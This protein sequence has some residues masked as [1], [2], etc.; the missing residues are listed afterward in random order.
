MRS[1]L[2]GSPGPGATHRRAAKAPRL[3]ALARAVAA[4]GLLAGAPGPMAQAVPAL[5]GGAQVQAG[6]ATITT[7]GAQMTVRNS[8]GTVLNWQ[9]FNIGAG[10]GVHFEQAGASSRVL[11]RVVG[12]DPSQIFG[13]LSSNGQVWLLNPHGVL[14]GA[15]ARVDVAGLVASTLRLSDNDFLAGRLR[16]AAAEGDAATAVRNEGTLATVNGGHVVLLGSR[17]E[18][19]GDVQAP[20]GQAMLVAG[21]TV[22]LADT[23]LPHIGVRLREGAGEVLNAGSIRTPGGRIDLHAAIVNHEGVLRADT[24]AP[25]AEGR[26]VLRAAETLTLGPRSVTAATGEGGGRGGAVDLLG[27]RVALVG[28]ARVDVSGAEGGGSVRLGGGAQGRDTS[29]PNARAVYIGSGAELNAD[30]SGPRG[31]G[32]R[33]VVWSDEATRAY[34]RFSAR[35]GAQGGDGGF[36]ETSGGW[37]DARPAAM[38]LGARFGRPGQWLLDPYDLEIV[39][40][41]QD[42]NVGVGAGPVFTS[43]GVRS[44]LT[45]AT[46]AAALNGGASVRVVTGTAPDA[47]QPGDILMN[48]ATLAVAPA[49]AV[50]LTLDAG[51]DIVITGGSRIVSTAAPLSLALSAGASTPGSIQVTDSELVTRGGDIT[52]RGATPTVLTLPDGSTVTRNVAHGRVIPQQFASLAGVELQGATLDLGTGTLTAA[53]Y[54]GDGAGIGGA[55]VRIRDTEGATTITAGRIDLFGAGQAANLAG[56]VQISGGSTLTATQS[57]R[58]EGSGDTGVSVNGNTRLALNAAAGSGATFTIVG[59]GGAGAGAQFAAWVPAPGATVTVANAAFDLQAQS[60]GGAG[61]SAFNPEAPAGPRF[62]LAGATG[63][64]FDVTVPAGATGGFPSIDLFDTTFVLP[65]A[66]AT[67]FSGAGG[68][69]L[70]QVSVQ[71]GRGALSFAAPRI[72][73]LDSTLVGNG[74]AVDFATTGALPGGVRLE[75]STLT[76]NGGDV[77]FG[78]VQTVTSPQ[79]GPTAAPGPWLE[80]ADPQ[81]FAPALGLLSSLVDAGSGTIRGGGA[82]RVVGSS[83]ASGVDIDGSTLR[84]RQIQLAGRSEAGMGLFVAG[85]TLAA[86]EQLVLDGRSAGADAFAVGLRL[87][88]G[89]VLQVSDAAAGAG[90]ELR[91]RGENLFGARGLVIEGGS[92]ADG[93]TPTRITAN[94][95][96]LSLEGVAAGATGL[97]LVGDAVRQGA[98]ALHAS[99]AQRTAAG[100]ADRGASRPV[101]QGARPLAVAPGTSGL[102]LDARGATSVTLRGRSGGGVGLDMQSVELQAP[103]FAG[104]TTTLST[105]GALTIGD[106]LISGIGPVVLQAQG[107]GVNGSLLSLADTTL[108]TGSA[109]TIDGVATSGGIGVSLRGGNVLGGASVSIA[110]NGSGGPGVAFNAAGLPSSLDA[111]AGNLTVDGGAASG[112]APTVSFAGGWSLRATGTVSLLTR[113]AVP[114]VADAQTGLPTFSGGQAFVLSNDSPGGLVVGTAAGS[115]LDASALSQALATMPAAATSTVQATVGSGTLAVDAPLSVPSRLA[116]LADRIALGA[117]GS[118]AAG[119]SGDAIVLGGLSTP[120]LASF[121]NAST[122]G[123]GALATPAGRWVILLD[124]PRQAALGGLTADFTAFGLAANP[125]ARDAAGNFITPFA[126][127]AFGFGIAPATLTGSAGDP[128]TAS[129]N[130]VLEAGRF[131]VWVPI[132]MSTPTKSR[133]FDAAVALEGGDGQPQGTM[134]W[135]GVSREEAMT[136]L[137]A[138][139]RYKQK[140]FAKGVY[141]LQED[142]RLADAPVCATEADLETGKCLVTEEL[143]Q[144]IQA[145]RQAA[146]GAAGPAQEAAVALPRPGQRRVIQAEL[147]GI[148]RKLALL[149]GVNKYDDARVPELTG[150]V[151]DVRAVRSLLEGRLGYETTVLENPRREDILRA[152]NRLALQALTGDSVIVYYAGHGVV[153]PVEGTETGFWLPSDVDAESPASWISNADIARLVAAVGAR[154]LMLVSDSCYSGALV[155]KERVQ[156]GGGQLDAEDLLKRRAA[157]VMSSGGDEPVADSGRDGH[158]IF[159]WHFMRALETLDRWQPGG[160]L[161]ERVRDAVVKD[162][163]QTPQYGASRT[164]GHQGG[165]DYLFE[166]RALEGGRP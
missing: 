96:A 32:G 162:F 159:A 21:R 112:A 6:Q 27:A 14:F 156:L 149:I 18:N 135:S 59:R 118:L 158:S 81:A 42:I 166:R 151:P 40:V 87:F 102:T 47:T 50:T 9:S 134:D 33:I 136:L 38:D 121:T 34:G 164:A 128:A 110:G 105:T 11:N 71:G 106:S 23:G 75:N 68:I 63:V 28:E 131:A 109:L 130:H 13:T 80:Q 57:L 126:G 16:F 93:G 8:P 44:T 37:L 77:R 84:A 55:G 144:R 10:A 41:G 61:F 117:G 152:F 114:L 48:G 62:D 95:A 85:S 15:G 69:G 133:M 91:L 108:T 30:A 99:R 97:Q 39:E 132:E 64:R 83:F 3:S 122:A 111:T 82:T 4:L 150:A 100:E 46:L 51:R 52:L 98:L 73:V 60:Q 7:L 113:N 19:T 79:L 148:Q 12:N 74:F 43:T 17:V 58:I 25:D 155:G 90:S 145:A 120:V 153:V 89:T 127:D 143:K 2:P 157:V 36:V 129:T 139:G 125:W 142:P 49:A 137:A 35:G 78:A 1:P 67:T 163:P 88:D 115:G 86:G 161:F 22:E 154:Q 72:E 146:A 76:T 65:A 66:G 24:L 53:G 124:D 141:R 123:A 107:A 160:K 26:I 103:S 140:V 138:R 56:G 20:G 94:G 45:T 54:S 5:P 29:V 70:T 101:D 165:T 116:L 104:R 119:G 92:A 147:P 31:D